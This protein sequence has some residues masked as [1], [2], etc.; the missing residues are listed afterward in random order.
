MAGVTGVARPPSPE[1]RPARLTLRHDSGTGMVSWHGSPAGAPGPGATGGE[2]AA[3]PAVVC[4]NGAGVS[5]R[6]LRPLV[7]RLAVAHDAW[8]VDLPGFGQSAKPDVALGLPALAEAMEDWL[9]AAGLPEVVLVGTS[10]GCQIA[11]EAAVRFPGR[12]RGLVLVGPT[13]DPE[14]RA[15][16][17]LFTRWLVNSVRE[18][19][20]MARLNLADYRDAGLRRVFGA[21]R[22][23][24][25]DRIEDKLPLVTAPT[26]VVRGE[27]DRLVDQA[28]AEEVTRL[29]P[30]GRL[31]VLP[32][33][34]HM[35]PFRDPDALVPHIARFLE[36]VS[37][38]RA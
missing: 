9:S 8:T 34:P 3:G 13:V 1:R 38:D 37:V 7:S 35:V 16:A 28:W 27:Y 24:M 25:R 36:E 11:V 18:D 32:E 17:P 19:P 29:L 15:W 5:S 22:E 6:E 10:F 21:F 2:P 4:V 12:V 33:L 31:R 20:R 14:G 23:A 30:K 26:L